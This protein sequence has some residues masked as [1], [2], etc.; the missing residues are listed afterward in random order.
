MV[1]S[2]EEEVFDC[3]QPEGLGLMNELADNCKSSQQL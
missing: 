1:L 2:P 3:P